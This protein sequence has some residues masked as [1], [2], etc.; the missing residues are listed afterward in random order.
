ME[1]LF[2]THNED[3]VN[4]V[5]SILKNYKI[6]SLKDLNDND[7]VIEDGSS[8]KEN[9]YKKA[10]YFFE[11]YKIPTISDDSGLVVASLAGMPGIN[12]ARY[13]G[14]SA[15]Y[16]T[17]NEK[18][19]KEMENKQN[20]DAYFITVICYV[21]KL[22]NANYFSGK[23]FGTIT[24][25]LRGVNGFGYDP[26]FY[27]SKYKK[28]LA[29]MQGMKQKISHRFLALQYLDKFLKEEGKNNE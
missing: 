9:A 13:A 14:E 4:E 18:L 24:E 20:R 6:Y 19:I 8:F 22:G 15:N 29:E 11:K 26:I 12:S 21:D 1:I 23:L 28:T 5:K 3:K 10:K 27:I 16:K 25:E 17:N 7:D 2:A